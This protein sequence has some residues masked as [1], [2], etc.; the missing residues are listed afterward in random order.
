MT[1]LVDATLRS[2]AIV[3]I[4][5]VSY[6]ASRRRSAAWRHWMLAAGVTTALVAIPATMVLP[7]WTVAAP[8]PLA[9]RAEPVGT[10]IVISAS[11]RPAT[12]AQPWTTILL[13]AWGIGVAAGALR[14]GA[15]TLRLRTATRQAVRVENHAWTEWA[16]HVASVHHLRRPV[17]IFMTRS[18]D[19][20]ATWGVFRPQI[21][22][23]SD[24]DSWSPARARI[25]LSHELAH[26]RRGDWAVQVA[27]DLLRTVFWFNPLIWVV[28]GRLRLESEHACDDEVLAE[29]VAAHDY[30]DHLLEIARTRRHARGLASALS[31]ARAST[32]EGRIAAMLNHDRDRRTPSLLTRLGILVALVLAMVPVAAFNLSA[33]GGP[34]ALQVAVYDPTGGVLPGAEIALEH[35]QQPTRSAITDASG[36]VTFDAVAPG[37][38]TLEATVAGFRPLRTVFTLDAAGDWQRAVTLQVGE[39]METVS[40]SAPR[41]SAARPAAGAG[42]EPLRVGGNIRAPRKLNHVTPVYPPA[43]RDAG[44]E[45]VVPLEAL[46]GKDGAVTSVQVLSAQIHPEFARAAE[47]AVRQWRFSP[48]LLNGAAVD[49]RMKLS[50]RFSL[51]D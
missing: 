37:E 19:T 11:A 25:V 18:R 36:A 23:P 7:P 27:A 22:L 29:G 24:A 31:M 10:A 12:T 1:L 33:Q 39:L 35:P 20:L 47:E 5:L 2:S 8:R 50:V 48:T 34:T 49:V 3:L 40:V 15:G 28:C 17:A 43:M 45:G 41:T 32:L 42:A 46:I 6:F 4:A 14:L 13:V 44:L 21:L 26:V 9:Q 16:A 30:A 38:Y 51:V